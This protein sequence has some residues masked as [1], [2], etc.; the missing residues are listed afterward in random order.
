MSKEEYD[1]DNAFG[2]GIIVGAVLTI[3]VIITFA[4]LN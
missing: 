3:L 2:A 4:Y 1:L